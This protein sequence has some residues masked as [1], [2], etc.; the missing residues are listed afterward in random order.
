MKKIFLTT[1]VFFCVII[2][3][4]AQNPY[5]NSIG[6]TVGSI[7]AFSWKTFPA[8][9]FAI[10]LDLGP[11]FTI[12][13]FKNFSANVFSAEGNLNFMYQG[14]FTKGLYGFAGAGFSMGYCWNWT[15]HLGFWNNYNHLGKFG[16][17]AILG[18]EYK[19]NAPVTMQ[20]DFRPGYGMLFNDNSHIGYFDW[21]LCLGVRYAF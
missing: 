20:F 7:E 9:H 8:N 13:A 6:A 3:A 14:N 21:A 16:A 2:S 18:L 15:Y 11:R 4:Q 1:F 12:G 19:F 5:K 17:N 10:Q